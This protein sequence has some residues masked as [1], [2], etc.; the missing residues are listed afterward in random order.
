MEISCGMNAVTV[1]LFWTV[2]APMVFPTID[3]SHFMSAWMGVRM[4]TLHTVPFLT[5]YANLIL[6]D[7]TM[8][9]SDWKMVAAIGVVYQFANYIGTKEMGAPIYPIADWKSVPETS[10]LYTLAGFAMGGFFYLAANQ[11]IKYR[12]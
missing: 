10:F 2:L 5:T 9:P 11:T 3:W 6:S 8:I 1:I 12:K 4:I 7:V